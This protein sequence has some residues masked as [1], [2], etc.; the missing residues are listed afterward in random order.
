MAQAYTREWYRWQ[1]WELF[2]GLA[3][4][5][6]SA[7]FSNYKLF[8]ES[9][10]EALQVMRRYA[11]AVI[12]RG[13]GGVYLYGNQGV[14]KTHLAASVLTSAITEGVLGHYYPWPVLV[15]ALWAS[16]QT[17]T[18]CPE[19]EN[20]LSSPLLVVDHLSR[21]S[22]SRW[23]IPKFELLV[24][25]RYRH[26]LPT[27]WISNCEPDELNAITPMVQSRF[28]CR[29]APIWIDGPDYRTTEE[30]FTTSRGPG[31][32]RPE[33]PTIK[34]SYPE[35]IQTLSETEILR[36]S[37]MQSNWCRETHAA[38]LR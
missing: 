7:L 11:N 3:G 19:F 34:I 30:Y 8:T 2:S 10:S 22:W 17:R 32:P 15:E 28:A 14:G 37:R 18:S 12:D 23:Q 31:F 29:A 16:F 38:K 35:Y 13:S 9:Q 36:Y 25:N 4:E 1:H 26:G 20:A 6:K 5:E 27:I 24:D 33:L 21:A